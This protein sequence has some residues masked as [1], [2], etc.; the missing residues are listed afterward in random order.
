MKNATSWRS[1]DRTLSCDFSL[2]LQIALVADDDHRE[3][4]LVFHSQDLLL[5]CSDFLEALS[6][7]DGVDQQETLSR[8][9][10]LL[11]HG[12]VLLLT[13]GIENVEQGDLLVDNAL[14]AVG[15]WH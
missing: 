14:L 10:V 8:S 4:V 2:T 15:I 6:R 3:V 7:R 1:S 9:H 11:S 12:G 5:E 13:G